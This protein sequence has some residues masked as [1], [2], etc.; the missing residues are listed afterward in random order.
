MPQAIGFLRDL[1]AAKRAVEADYQGWP[2]MPL[3]IDVMAPDAR[4]WIGKNSSTSPDVPAF[5]IV[6][7]MQAKA[8]YTDAS[9][10]WAAILRTA[11]RYKA[12]HHWGKKPWLTH[13]QIGESLGPGQWDRSGGEGAAGV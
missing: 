3:T 2:V 4:T 12:R 1:A 6:N 5:V 9:R 10:V 8:E 13:E 7:L 11:V